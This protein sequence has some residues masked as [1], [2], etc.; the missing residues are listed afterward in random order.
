MDYIYHIVVPKEKALKLN[1]CFLKLCK[2]RVRPFIYELA[3]RGF[4]GISHLA[5]FSLSESELEIFNIICDLD[6]F[7]IFWWKVEKETGKLDECNDA[8]CTLFL[9]EKVDPKQ[10]FRK[11]GFIILPSQNG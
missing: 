10:L 11:A 2:T 7:G 1:D 6:D 8:D 3:S 4:C 9:G 5:A